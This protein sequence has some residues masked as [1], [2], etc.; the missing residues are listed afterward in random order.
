LR[1]MYRTVSQVDMVKLVLVDLDDTMWRGVL[2]EGAEVNTGTREGWP[3]GFAETLLTLKRRGVLLGIVSKN[4]ET[5]ATEILR[6]VHGGQL[7]VSDFAIHRI[8]WRPKADNI[9][10]ILGEVNLLPRSV[11]FID[12]NPVERASVKAAFPD[13]RVIGEN[14]YLWR[15]ILLWSPETQVASI[16]AESASRTA[17][18]QAQVEREQQRKQLTRDDFLASLDVNLTL[19]EVAS[20]SHQDFP[21]LLE[22]INKT[23]QFNTTGQRRTFQECDDFIGRGGRFWTMRVQDRYT[24]YGLVGVLATLDNSITQFVMSCRVVGLD[25][26]FAAVAGL[27]QKMRARSTANITASLIET[28][29]KPKTGTA[30]LVATVH[31]SI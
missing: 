22:L 15:R 30:R 16:T 14:P 23:N 31:K 2:A 29:L 20:L 9:E 24:S 26:E 17:M 13:M 10:E 21:R 25:V 7:T 12:D 8:N 3:L 18:V 11:V 6:Q 4:E 27:I 19:T 28:H 1:A 5:R